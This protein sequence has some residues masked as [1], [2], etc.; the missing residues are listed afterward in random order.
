MTASYFEYLGWVSLS[1]NLQ[2][3]FAKALED[4][5]KR[6]HKAFRAE[7]LLYALVDDPE[8]AIALARMQV[9]RNE[10]RSDLTEHLSRFPAS[11]GLLPL[12]A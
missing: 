12:P 4:A 2:A 3:S 6:G 11:T 9:S 8:G 7:H 5:R 10:L 1:S